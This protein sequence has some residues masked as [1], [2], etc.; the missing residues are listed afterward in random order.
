MSVV[1]LTVIRSELKV[2]QVPGEENKNKNKVVA[3]TR[4]LNGQGQACRRGE[5]SG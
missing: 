1:Y 5:D 4:W 3:N 2:E